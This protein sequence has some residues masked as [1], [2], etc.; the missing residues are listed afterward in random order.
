MSRCLLTMPALLLV[1]LALATEAKQVLVIHT[2]SRISGTTVPFE[3]G[4]HQVLDANAAQPVEIF[5]EFLD[6]P[7][8]GGDRHELTVTNYL[9]DKYADRPLDAVVVGGEAALEFILRHRDR[10]FPGVPVLHV[11]VTPS[12]LQSVSPLPPDVVGVPMALDFAG[13]VEL[14]LKWRPRAT[15]L[16]IVTG[17]SLQDDWEPVISPQIAPILGPVHAEYLVGLPLPALQKQLRDLGGESVVL[18]MGFH[19]DRDGR[20]YVLGDSIALIV[21]ASSAPVYSATDLA[22]GSGVVGGRMLSYEGTGR[23]YGQILERLF[24]GQPDWRT[25]PETNPSALQVDWREV[26]RWGIDETK[27]P[28]EAIVL[29]REPSLWD[30]YRKETI[31]AATALLLLAGL[32]IALLSER[33]SLARTSAALTASEQG[34][35]LAARAAKLAMWIWNVADDRI[36]VAPSQPPFQSAGHTS[37]KFPDALAEVHPADREEVTRTVQKALDDNR[38]LDLEYRTI[39]R[40]GE[41]R[42]IAIRGRP[43]H[44]DHLQWLGIVLDIT[45]RKQA[46]LQAARDR[47][48]LQHLARVSMLGQMSAAIAHQLNQPLTSIL[49]NAEA[50]Q[51]MLT[52]EPVDLEE[53][54]QICDDIVSQDQR[55]A[56][57]IRRLRALFK[58]EDMQIQQIDLNALIAESLDLLHPNLTTDRITVTTQ[59]AERLHF[60]DGDKIQVQQ[61]LL[62]LIMNAADAMRDIPVVTRRLVIGTEAADGEIRLRVTDHGPGIATNDLKNIFEPFWSAKPA[63][64]GIGLSI[65]QSIVAAHHG[66]LTAVNNPE[67]GATFIVVFPI[68]QAA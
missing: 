45:D 37:I 41:V 68:P 65:C 9:H 67:G 5:S 24:S 38:E 52:R 6:E 14:A 43:D 21:A 40:D 23:Q 22:L 46:E 15:R 16:V 47:N 11:G 19:R 2:T 13:T 20:F 49:A 27:I 10:L 17:A 60:F 25:M 50:A 34:M 58:R 42:W 56:A 48:A 4:L 12:A 18:T 32:S 28:K 3:T 36:S 44:G 26:K 29:F 61:V 59:L 54:K 8:F 31:S 63:G 57:V 64:M 62:N 66:T 53:V 39:S 30:A 55:A 33:R 51:Q 1:H 7:R 35:T